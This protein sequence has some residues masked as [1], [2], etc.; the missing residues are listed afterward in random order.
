MVRSRR[1]AWSRS[2]I[3]AVK[4]EMDAGDGRVFEVAEI[5]AEGRGF[6]ELRQDAVEAV[7]WEGED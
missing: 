2:L 3:L 6:G 4:P 5:F 7:E 1:T